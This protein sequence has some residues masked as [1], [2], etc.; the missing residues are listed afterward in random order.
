MT[1][2]LHASPLTFVLVLALLVFSLLALDVRSVYGQTLEEL[3]EE[4]RSALSAS[5][6]KAEAFYSKGKFED[7]LKAYQSAY[8]ILADPNILYRIALCHER[9]GQYDEAIQAYRSY[10]EQNPN[11]PDKERISGVIRSLEKRRAPRMAT[12]RFRIQ[13]SD[14]ALFIDGAQRLEQPDGE[15]VIDID[16]PPGK[17]DIRVSKEGHFDQVHKIDTSAGESYPLL[18]SLS[19]IPPEQE[20]RKPW[21]PTSIL[22]LGGASTV[23]GALFLA[24]ARGA[25]D[26]LQQQYENRSTSPR[27]TGYGEARERVISRQRNG[28]ILVGAGAALSIAGG[29]WL[30][31]KRRGATRATVSTS[32]RLSPSDAGATLHVLF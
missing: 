12:L 3:T 29:T 19:Q 23:T 25:N 10:L 24:S 7:A 27:P 1:R 16:L 18:L 4:Q 20:G 22:V 2:S 8:K 30:T 26:V 14:A 6:A 9:S 17:H 13:P 32:A 21:V 31:I 28:L 15:G 5:L 11:D